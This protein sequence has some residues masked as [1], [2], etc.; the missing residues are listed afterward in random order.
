VLNILTHD[1][2]SYEPV[3]GWPRML[4]ECG[5]CGAVVVPE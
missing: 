5:D 4:A 1:P 2:I 3:D